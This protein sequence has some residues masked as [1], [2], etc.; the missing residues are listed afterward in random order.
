MPKH[1]DRPKPSVAII[2]AGRL[3][4]ALAIALAESGYTVRALVARRA[5]EAKKAAVMVPRNKEPVQALGAK[6]LAKLAPTDLT[7]IST[8]DDAIEE[9]A[10]KLAALEHNRGDLKP[11]KTRGRIALHTSGA[12][13]SVVLAPLAEAGFHTGSLH[14]LVSVSDPR[15]GAKDLRGAFY[16]VE[17]DKVATRVARRIVEDFGGKSF[18]I[19][20]ESKALYHAAA[21]T[22]AGHLTAL[23]DLAMEMLVSCGL[24]RQAG[25]DVLMPLVESAVNNLKDSPPENALTGTFARG[26]VATVERHLEALSGNKQ[27]EA[28]MVY[29]LLGLRSLQLAGKKG[30]DER[31]R[32]KIRKLLK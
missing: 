31:V 16:C 10:Q 30:I 11:G 2:G 1:S 21:L 14:P 24:S 29:K 15:S 32:Q 12:L 19:A 4:R 23:I 8:P 27:A 6:E 17:G 25:Q 20:P 28:L 9:T 5:S 3:G 18:S 7:L 26:D 22:A 13:S